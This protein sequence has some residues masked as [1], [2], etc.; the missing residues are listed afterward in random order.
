MKLREES[1]LTAGVPPIKSPTWERLAIPLLVAMKQVGNMTADE[2]VTWGVGYDLSPH[3]S[4][5]VL[6]WLS[7]YDYV[8]Y[9]DIKRAWSIGKLPQFDHQ[10]E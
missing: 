10:V 2:V 9:D 1:P 8:H 4:K 6:A 7:F 5:H 3:V